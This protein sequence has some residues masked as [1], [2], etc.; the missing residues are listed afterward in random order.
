MSTIDDGFYEQ[1]VEEENYFISMTDMMV[2]LV[3]IFIIL[4]MYYALQFRQTID[5]FDGSNQTRSEILVDLKH[6]LQSY[7][8]KVDIDTRTGVLH[9]PEGIL[10]DSGQ[11]VIKPSGVEALGHLADGLMLI[12]PCYSDGVPKPASCKPARHMI[13]S[14]FV[15][16]HTDSDK[17]VGRLGIRD[18]WDL[19]VTRA[20]N[21]Y[22]YFA[23]TQP[24]LIKLC[25][26]VEG[27]GCNQVMSVSGYS[28]THPIARGDDLVSK[29]ENRRI[30]LRILMAAPKASET[31]PIDAGLNDPK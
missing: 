31:T 2:G 3:F 19:S 4:L 26:K 5:Q 18:N 16:G 1:H 9:L 22:R 7:N 24:N 27:G 23:E 20:T 15:E 21:T 17:L 29:S 11:A 10:F 28:D 25:L 8:I 30:D 14:V 13:E 6:Y 12:L